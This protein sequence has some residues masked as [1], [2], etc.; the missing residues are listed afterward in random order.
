MRPE[1]VLAGFRDL[2][3][4]QCL[5]AIV[6]FGFRPSQA[7]PR[8]RFA[9]W[10]VRKARSPVAIW[11]MPVPQLGWQELGGWRDDGRMTV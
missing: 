7:P 11:A 6:A 5:A 9:N 2:L 8:D 4:L 1:P 3:R 10:I